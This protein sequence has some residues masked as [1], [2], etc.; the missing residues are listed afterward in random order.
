[1]TPANVRQLRERHGLNRRQFAQL[2]WQSERAVTGWE[3][4]E[5]NMPKALYEL[6]LIKLKE[7]ELLA[8]FRRELCES[9]K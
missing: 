5:R 7:D 2:V 9:K 6:L 8:E 3:Y 4:G 1:M